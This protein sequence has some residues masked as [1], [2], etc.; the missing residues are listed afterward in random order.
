M[1]PT[2]IRAEILISFCLPLGAVMRQS[3]LCSKIKHLK[4]KAS[5]NKGWLYEH[6]TQLVPN[7][8]PYWTAVPAVEKPTLQKSQLE[9]R[10]RRTGFAEPAGIPDSW[11][12]RNC[13]LLRIYSRNCQ[14]SS[15][16]QEL[17]EQLLPRNKVT[18]HI[19]MSWG[20]E[21]CPVFATGLGASYKVPSLISLQLTY[22]S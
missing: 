4:H 2:K 10:K 12:T 20:L 21:T 11:S 5:F 15:Q 7:S 9:V 16:A 22:N 1:V 8:V 14:S 17:W 18:G 13:K 3:V 19:R 6:E